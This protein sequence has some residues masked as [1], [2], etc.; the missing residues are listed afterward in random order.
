MTQEQLNKARAR[1]SAQVRGDMDAVGISIRDMATAA[2]VTTQSVQ[3]VRNGSANYTIDNYLRI[4]HVLDA[5]LK[6]RRSRA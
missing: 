2:E 4:R 6:K 5:R 1:I 3:V